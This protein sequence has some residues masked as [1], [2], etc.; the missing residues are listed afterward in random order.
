[1][2]NCKNKFL[3]CIYYSLRVSRRSADSNKLNFDTTMAMKIKHIFVVDDDEMMLSMIHDHLSRNP[4]HKISLFKTGE[5]CIGNMQLNPDVIILDYRLNA[6]DP[7]AHD[8][9]YVL[10][11][12]KRLDPSLPII[13]LSSQEQYG[14]ALETIVHG[15]VEY[16]VKDSDAFRRIDSILGP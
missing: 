16:V 5:D 9:L 13:M 12:L 15:A 1:M 7:N 3:T 6:V 11:A 10:Q 2:K 8:G 14:K 4:L